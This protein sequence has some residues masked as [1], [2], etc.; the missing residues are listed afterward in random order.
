MCKAAYRRATLS[1]GLGRRSVRCRRDGRRIRCDAR[2]NGVSVHPAKAAAAGARGAGGPHRPLGAAAFGAHQLGPAVPPLVRRASP[3]RPRLASHDVHQKPGQAVRPRRGRAVSHGGE[4]A[5][6]SVQAAFLG[7]L[8]AR[9]YPVGRLA[10][11]KS[12]R[13]QESAANP[14]IDDEGTGGGGGDFRGARLTNETHRSTTGPDAR[15]YRKEIGPVGQALPHGACAGR[16]P[17]RHGGR[18][19]GDGRDRHGGGGGGPSVVWGTA[20]AGGAAHGWLRQGL[21]REGIR[22]GKQEL[23]GHAPLRGEAFRQGG[24]WAH[25]PACGLSGELGQVP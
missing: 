21:W 3:G 15:L 18:G 24:G 10:S 4:R 16:E 17:Q 22:S 14:P 5:G 6:A 25:H 20:Q 9:R 7:P 23:E 12:F 8:P 11:I 13:L 1:A 2:R 19:L